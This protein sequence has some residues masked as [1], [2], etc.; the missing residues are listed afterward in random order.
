M[1]HFGHRHL[2]RNRYDAVLDVAP[3]EGAWKI[4]DFDLRSTERVK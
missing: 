2:R 3:M 4:R 1:T